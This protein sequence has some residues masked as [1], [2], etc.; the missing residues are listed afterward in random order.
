[1]PGK[2]PGGLF[3]RPARRVPGADRV[4]PGVYATS[5]DVTPSSLMAS[6]P[7]PH[8]PHRKG[9]LGKNAGKARDLLD[10]SPKPSTIVV[11]GVTAVY[12]SLSLRAR[13]KRIDEGVDEDFSGGGLRRSAD[14]QG[15]CLCW[16]CRGKRTRASSSTTTSRSLLSRFAATRFGSESRLRKRCPSTA[17]RCTRRSP[18]AN[19]SSNPGRLRRLRSVPGASVPPVTVPPRIAPVRRGCRPRPRIAI[20]PVTSPA[21]DQASSKRHRPLPSDFGARTGASDGRG[22][23]SV[24]ASRPARTDEHLHRRDRPDRC[25]AH[26]HPQPSRPPPPWRRGCG[27]SFASSGCRNA[28]S[29]V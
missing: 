26:R 23:R 19:R 22:V 12:P 4:S 15:R 5:P 20:N 3:P 24:A 21:D 10:P 11:G 9:P 17:E 16:S 13:G 7:T 28:P 6:T 2:S 25:S 18:A 1:V 14:R 29:P 27:D 8:S